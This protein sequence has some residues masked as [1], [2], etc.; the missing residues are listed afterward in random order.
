MGAEPA[1]LLVVDDE[2]LNR[3]GLARRLQKHGYAVTAAA[4]GR[5][6]IEVLGGRRFDLVLLDIMMP[7][8]T[9]L[10]VL[11]FLRRVDS[12]IDL[13]IVMV[14]AK[15]E[16]EDVIEA[17]ELGANDYVTKPLDFPVVLARIR[18][19]LSLK[20]AVAQV[21]DLEQTLDARNRELEAAAAELAATGERTRQ[22]LEAAARVQR[23]FRPA[24]PP[25]IP[26]ARLAWGFRPAGELSVDILDVF[27]IDGRRLGVCALDANGSGVAAALRS[28]TVAR[29]LARADGAPGEAL[30][31][32]SR[33]LSADGAD[34]QTFA[35]LYGVLDPGAGAFRFAA[36]GHPGPIHLARGKPP[37]GA[38]ATE[39]PLGV[40]P[41]RYAEHVVRLG[42]G[43]RLLIATDGL[44]EARNPDGE[45][46]GRRRLLAALDRTRSAPPDE[47]LA[48]VVA[49][50]EGWRGGA[51]A[52][53]DLAALLIDR[54]GESP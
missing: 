44:A 18:A 53:D 17:L 36:A 2:E 1:S 41:G 12:R 27:P 11:K 22:D 23:A 30:T 43:D 10:E 29:F 54:T 38:D 48:A 34:G 14:T 24:G 19:Q 7:G 4:S 16:S 40:G 39:L 45:H 49:E 8:M 37:A 5:E 47:S 28:A 35:L 13:P 52:H 15:G 51:D 26:G 33:Q 20:R 42:A 31:A 21:T 9:G 32:L 25:Q 46:F 3:E 6:A 50:A